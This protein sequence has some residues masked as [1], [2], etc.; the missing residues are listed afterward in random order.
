MSPGQPKAAPLHPK[1]QG[2]RTRAGGEGGVRSPTIAATSRLPQAPGPRPSGSAFPPCGGLPA[3]PAAEPLTLA[4]A[5]RCWGLRSPT[6]P[7]M[8]PA[9]RGA[10]L[11]RTV[12]RPASVGFARRV[13]RWSRPDPRAARPA[14]PCRTG[15]R[16]LG[17]PLFVPLCVG[18]EV[19]GSPHPEGCCDAQVGREEAVATADRGSVSC[20]NEELHERPSP[21][22]GQ[23]GASRPRWGVG[24]SGP[25]PVGQE[26]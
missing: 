17:P 19:P 15:L 3:L 9:R 13:R 12:R 1:E 7:L 16:W 24:G 4:S 26:R 11:C 8:V 6:R 25:A 14:P 18:R 2:T 20:V 5:A 22:L 10:R 21:A 23:A